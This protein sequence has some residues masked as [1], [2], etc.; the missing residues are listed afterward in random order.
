MSATIDTQSSVTE[1][2]RRYL[3]SR[4]QALIIDLGAIED[5][6]GLERSIVPRRKREQPK[7]PRELMEQFD[8]LT[9]GQRTVH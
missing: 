5:Y 2:E 9:Q 3:M 7:P 1:H 8:R 6:L 4:R